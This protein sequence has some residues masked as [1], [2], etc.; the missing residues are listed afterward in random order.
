MRSVKAALLNL[1]D[2]QLS[3]ALTKKPHQYG[4]EFVVSQVIP[5]IDGLSFC[6]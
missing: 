5:E 4:V 1:L 3:L 2:I 6:D